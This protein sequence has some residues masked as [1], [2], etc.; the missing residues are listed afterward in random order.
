MRILNSDTGCDSEEGDFLKIFCQRYA[1]IQFYGQLEPAIGGRW[2]EDTQ[3]NGLEI[4]CVLKRVLPRSISSPRPRIS[5]R[6][7]ESPTCPKYRSS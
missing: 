7:Y 1:A 6:A 4:V 5:E 2:E 3:R